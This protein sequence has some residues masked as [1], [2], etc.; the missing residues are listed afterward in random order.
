MVASNGLVKSS[1][2]QGRDKSR[3][4]RYRAKKYIKQSSKSVHSSMV[5][6]F[7]LQPSVLNL[8]SWTSLDLTYAKLPVLNAGFLQVE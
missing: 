3:L 8:Y 5:I 6:F 7:V 1:L 2:D 4:G